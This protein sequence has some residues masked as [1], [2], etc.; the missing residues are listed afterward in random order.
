VSPSAS[1]AP[2]TVTDSV[3]L[4]AGRRLLRRAPV[5]SGGVLRTV[6]GS[7][8]TWFPV[9]SPSYGVSWQRIEAPR[10]KSAPV[11]VGAEPAAR[12]LTVHEVVQPD[13]SPSGSLQ[14]RPSQETVEVS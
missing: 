14:P 7:L 3:S 2:S 4:A 6:T 10:E 1:N 5:A 11:K 12:P 8:V 13:G 9:A